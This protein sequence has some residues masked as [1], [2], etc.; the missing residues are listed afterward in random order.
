MIFEFI[1]KKKFNP[2]FELC[3]V[4]LNKEIIKKKKDSSIKH[5]AIEEFKNAT[6]C[7]SFVSMKKVN[8]ARY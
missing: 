1:F 6:F 4:E 2:G 7:S 5:L 8:N 3:R